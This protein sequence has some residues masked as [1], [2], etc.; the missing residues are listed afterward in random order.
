MQGTS[1]PKKYSRKKHPWY[2]NT[3]ISSL[4]VISSGYHRQGRLPL[5][6]IRQFTEFNCTYELGKQYNAT[7]EGAG[8]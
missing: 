2:F 5:L 4:H 7:A 3:L 1:K 6:V 8:H